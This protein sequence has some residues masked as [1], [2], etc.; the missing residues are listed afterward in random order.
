MPRCARVC[1]QSLTVVLVALVGITAS[2]N[3]QIASRY[4]PTLKAESL[5]RRAVCND[6][7]NAACKESIKACFQDCNKVP[8]VDLRSVCLRRCAHEG[9]DCY[10]ACE[11]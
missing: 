9:L 3:E 7:Q 8:D 11:R 2:A 10:K 6:S 1:I 5:L 4:N